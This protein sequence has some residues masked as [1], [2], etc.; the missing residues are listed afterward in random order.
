M[1]VASCFSKEWEDKNSQEALAQIRRKE[2]ALLY[3]ADGRKIFKIG[4]NFSSEKRNID[5]WIIEEYMEHP[6]CG[7]SA[8]LWLS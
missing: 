8:W 6:D 3:E 1:P 4:V 2:Y 5:K 7:F